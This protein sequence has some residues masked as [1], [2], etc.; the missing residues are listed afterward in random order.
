MEEKWTI[1]ISIGADGGKR[2][3]FRR[4]VNGEVKETYAHVNEDVASIYASAVIHGFQP[5]RIL[6]R[7][8]TQF[9]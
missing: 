9:R 8:D 2:Y 1:D 3:M 7:I 4:I 6:P 5:P